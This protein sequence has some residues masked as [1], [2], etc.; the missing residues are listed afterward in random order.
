MSDESAH[1]PVAERRW[2]SPIPL[3]DDLA[4]ISAQRAYGE[5]FFVYGCFFF[6]SIGA[7]ILSLFTTYR[8]GS[9]TWAQSIPAS[10]NQVAV[11]ALAVAVPILLSLRR[12]VR[13]IDLGLSREIFQRPAQAIRIAA[14]AS[15]AL[16][17]FGVVVSLLTARHFPF[18]RRTGANLLVEIMHSLQAGPLEEIVVLGFVVTTLQ[19][20][21]RPLAE[22]VIVALVLRDA[23]H[24]YY[25]LGAL[26]IFVWASLFI[27][28]YL[29]F[30]TLIPLIIVHSTWDVFGTLAHYWRPAG[31]IEI[32]LIL[33]LWI[34]APITWLVLRASTKQ[35]VHVSG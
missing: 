10:I 3:R 26:G 34:A 31:V 27:W 15:F 6:A 12:G 20:A 14:W 33:A 23:F 17:L 32:L 22:I 9:Y 1:Q 24:L 30:R 16:I 7:A 21:R 5:V 8:S 4:P 11:T 2:Y 35:Y 28:L 13:L 25:G 18:P 19:Q 29:R